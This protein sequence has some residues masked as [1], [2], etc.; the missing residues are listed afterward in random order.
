M[1][2]KAQVIDNIRQVASSVLPQG[3]K[4]FLYG[5]TKEPS[6]CYTAVILMNPYSISLFCS[7]YEEDVTFMHIVAAVV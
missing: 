7:R 5:I 6:R 3:S 2:D 4:L 1:M